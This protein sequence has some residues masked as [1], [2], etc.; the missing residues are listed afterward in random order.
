L[1]FTFEGEIAS[2]REEGDFVEAE[3]RDTGTG[4]PEEELPTCS[5][6]SIASAG[7]RA[8]THEG[9]GSGSRWCALRLHG[10]DLRVESRSA[11]GPD[12]RP[13]PKG[14]KTLPRI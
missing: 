4:I 6:A 14:V 11:A 12:R 9:K 10:G 1:K 13:L 7:A 5:S 8:R 3:V 2:R